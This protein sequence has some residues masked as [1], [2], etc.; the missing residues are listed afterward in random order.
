M[1]VKVQRQKF[2]RMKL[3]CPTTQPVETERAN[4]EAAPGWTKDRCSGKCAHSDECDSMRLRSHTPGPPL[5]QP[6]CVLHS[7]IFTKQEQ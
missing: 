4:S 5:T 7:L 2:N 6:P 3:T 1:D